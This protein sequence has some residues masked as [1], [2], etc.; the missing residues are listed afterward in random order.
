MAR[1]TMRK[2]NKSL[3]WIIAAV[4]VILVAAYLF[5]MWQFSGL[6]EP[7]VLPDDVE[8]EAQ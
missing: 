1:E 7:G 8:I 6:D 2:A 5:M 4:V 3:Y